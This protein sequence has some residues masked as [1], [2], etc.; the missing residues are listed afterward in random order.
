[1][2]QPTK[3]IEGFRHNSFLVDLDRCM[4]SC[5][6][7]NDLSNRICV[8]NLDVFNMITGINQLKI[9]TKH[10]SCECKC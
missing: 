4:G 2:N 7:L 8:P 9:L 5:T 1:M 10:T 6:T 3:Y